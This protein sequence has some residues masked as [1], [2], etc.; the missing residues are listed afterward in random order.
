MADFNRLVNEH[1]R[2]RYF[3]A[4]HHEESTVAKKPHS[5]LIHSEMDFHCF[6]GQNEKGKAS[7]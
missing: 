7:S 3:Y 1:C 5:R 4:G 6:L 2:D